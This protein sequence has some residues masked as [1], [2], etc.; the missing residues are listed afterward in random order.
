MSREQWSLQDLIQSRQR[1]G[2]VGRRAQVSQFVENLALEVDDERRRFLFNIHGDAGVGK[3]Y[4]T[5]H[6]RQAAAERGA[7][8]AYLDDRIE[9]L[10]SAMSMLARGLSPGG[11]WMEEFRKRADAYLQRRHELASDPH[12]PDG[13]A[14]FLTRT[15]VI[16]GL[17]A[18]RD[19]PFAGSLLAPVDAS[20][21]AD[22][23]NRARAYLAS[24]FRD[25][26]D[27]R[28]LLSPA[29]ELTPLFVSGLRR[30]AAKVGPVVLFIDTYERTGLLLDQWLR[31]MYAG[32]YGKL[33][34]TLVTVI[35][36]QAPLDPNNWSEYLPV[37]ADVPLDPFSDTEA[38]QFLASKGITE[39]HAVELI[40]KLS[41]R[42]PLWLATLASG[43]PGTAADIGD[44]VD[45]LVERFLKWE[46][47][48][49]RRAIAVA[50]A[51]PRNLNQDTLTPLAPDGQAPVLFAWLRSLPFVAQQGGIWRYHEVARAA[52]LRLQRTQAPSDWRSR[53]AA[54]AGA[55]ANWAAAAAGSVNEAWANPG[56]IDHTREETYH[57]LCA[58]PVNNLPQ[59][60]ASAVKATVHGAIRA[61][62]WAELIGDAGSDTDQSTLR[63]WGQLL[64]D[65]IH[66]DDV[67]EYLSVLISKAQLDEAGLLLALRERSN[68]HRL[69]GRFAEALDDFNRI[70]DVDP[71]LSAFSLPGLEASDHI[72][73]DFEIM[74]IFGL[75][76]KLYDLTGSSLPDSS[77]TIAQW[78]HMA[79]DCIARAR[80]VGQPLTLALALHAG[81][82]VKLAADD[83]EVAVE[84]LEEEYRQVA[85]VDGKLAADQA[86]MAL[87]LLAKLQ[88]GTLRNFKAASEAAT[89]AIELIER[90]RYQV[91]APSRQ[92]ALLS[93]HADLFTASVFS[94]WKNATDETAPDLAGY[95][96][97][98][99]QMEL[100]KARAS[101]RE[102]YP[103]SAPDTIGYDKRLSAL[104]NAIHAQDILVG[105]TQPAEAR[106]RRHGQVRRD[107]RP[108]RQQ[109]LQLWDLRTAARREP[110]PVMLAGLQAAL[111]A[112]EVVIYYYWLNSLVLLVVTMTAAAITAE[113][114]VLGPDQ[115]SLLERL[116][117]VLSSR[118]G[119]DRSLE[120]TFIEQLA[121]V[122]MPVEGRPLLEGK[123]RLILSPHQLLRWYPFAAMPYQERPLVQSFAIRYAPNL[124]SLLVPRL[125]VGAPAMAALTV[126]HSCERPELGAL[127]DAG[128]EAADIAAIYSAAAIPTDLMA[129]PTR[130]DVLASIHNGRLSRAWCLHL[131][132]HGYS[133]MDDISRDAPLESVLELADNS[134]DG[135]EIAAADLGCEVVVLPACYSGQRDINARGVPEQP[136]DELFGL[137]AAFLGARC[138]SVLAPAWPT[139][140][141]FTS[142]IITAFHRN[143]AMGSPADI[144]L[145]QA[146]RA[147]LDTASEKQPPACHWASLTLIA[148]GRP[149]SIPGAPVRQTASEVK[150]DARK[151]HA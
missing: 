6:L 124:T 85:G 122:L 13:V 105:P 104:N 66:D 65:S 137:T 84:L 23:A 62:Q 47:N 107:Q 106:E 127:R 3:T 67:T 91:S 5:L 114:K 61:R 19:L 144:A 79:D 28:L 57:L 102:L 73:A 39:K 72:D 134:V 141:K 95:D 14:D 52:M 93:P 38:R 58:D 131:A 4:L 92:A 1:S 26:A 75:V 71:Q 108:L 33:P 78:Q 126:S 119:P 149:I 59:A 146:Q 139:D 89:K 100:T 94:A 22:Q 48:P 32:R 40:L 51:L 145:A 11:D 17:Q 132:T 120:T 136:G 21:V 80:A 83:Y 123:Q 138:R 101:V 96:L 15:T 70:I 44:P 9:D 53:H 43:R 88:L 12:A 140:Y 110:P 56:W 99:Q 116:A 151:E 10:F 50:A 125:H 113:R 115:R 148:I 97:M 63:E 37:I 31:D 7:A 18:A 42:L 77:E 20:A 150:P 81:V 74:V 30:I 24:K 55:H 36:G 25:H 69:A 46:N 133:L 27:A 112:D 49:A 103:A 111:G 87:T 68:G 16:I 143:I 76:N 54:L 82:Q 129:G 2:F 34:G 109:R 8:A 130:A 45:D 35:S 41:G 147:I 90:D 142:R 64:S 60:L 29:E 121:P 98:L 118:K 86:I 117:E 135:Y 128:A